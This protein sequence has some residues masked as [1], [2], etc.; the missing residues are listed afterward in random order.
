MELTLGPVLFDWGRDDLLRF[1]EE[2]CDLD[3]DR[4]YIGEVVCSRKRRLSLQDLEEIGRMLESSGKKVVV[5]TLAVVSN[6][7]ELDIIRDILTLPFAVEAN[8][9]SVFNM[10]DGAV[11]EIVAGPHITTYNVPTIEFLKRLGIRWVTFPV[12]LPRRSIEHNIKATGI[13]GEVFGHGK[14]PLAFSWRC[15]TLRSYNL[16]RKDCKHQCS[17]YPEGME[18]KTLKGDPIFT[19]NGTSILSARTYT[20]VEFI[21]DLKNIGVRAV[22]ISPSHEDTAE[23]VDIFRQRMNGT[24]DGEE[25]IRRL[26]AM[27]RGDV[28]NGWY[29][30]G[31]GKDYFGMEKSFSS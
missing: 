24:M 13:S 29:L 23:I 7:E 25:A 19:V 12:E 20:L 2:V 10:V 5:S 17:L 11:R 14:V 30:G 15:Y 9:M 6:E 22:R 16:T 18:L 28:C 27:N 31:A 26:K 3:V 1:Y 8:D 4:V 21:E